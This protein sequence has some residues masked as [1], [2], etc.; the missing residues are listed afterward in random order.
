[1]QKPMI[2]LLFLSLTFSAFADNSVLE[3]KAKKLNARITKAQARLS[4]VVLDEA[5]QKGLEQFL[6]I[7][8]T[9]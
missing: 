7:I 3:A 9:S 6:D 1:M 8:Q 2:V 5:K 4:E